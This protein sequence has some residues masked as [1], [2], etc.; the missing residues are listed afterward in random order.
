MNHM[1]C[2]PIGGVIKLNV[3][4]KEYILKVKCL[5]NMYEILGKYLEKVGK[6]KENKKLEFLKEVSV[7][8]FFEKISDSKI[9]DKSIE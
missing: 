5:I 3:H 8:D 7:E 6:N 2:R 9:E 1:V 4:S